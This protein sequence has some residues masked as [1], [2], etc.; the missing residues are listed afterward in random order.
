MFFN[1]SYTWAVRG[2][3]NGNGL[4]GVSSRD[5]WDVMWSS[6]SIIIPQINRQIC[7]NSFTVL[8]IF[9]LTY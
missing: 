3:E 9:R 1:F 7:R 2:N 4:C 6:E 5:Y 8:D